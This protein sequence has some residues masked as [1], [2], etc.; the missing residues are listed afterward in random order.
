MGYFGPS[1]SVIPTKAGITKQEVFSRGRE[2]FSPVI[3]LGTVILRGATRRRRIPA[4]CFFH[5]NPI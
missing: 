5:T 2:R 3:L 1:N 4:P